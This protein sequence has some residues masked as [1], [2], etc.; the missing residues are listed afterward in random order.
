MMIRPVL[1]RLHRTVFCTEMPTSFMT[2]MTSRSVVKPM[3]TKTGAITSST[4]TPKA[5][6]LRAGVIDCNDLAAG[7]DYPVDLPAHLKR[8]LDRGDHVR[9]HDEV[10][11]IVGKVQA[12]ASMT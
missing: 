6:V 9:R 1:S 3:R 12:E 11:I 4:A 10:E 8:I 5:A 2:R 7:L